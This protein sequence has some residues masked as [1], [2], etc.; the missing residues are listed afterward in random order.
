MPVRAMLVTLLVVLAACG[1][2]GRDLE[3]VQP[4]D[5]GVPAS[6]TAVQG[7]YRTTYG[8]LMQLR[9]N[10]EFLMVVPDAESQSGF[11]TL[12]EGDFRVTTERCGSGVTGRYD[13]V[14]TGQPEPNK[15][16]LEFHTVSDPCE[17]RAFYLVS[18]PW[19]YA[20]S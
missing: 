5:L 10:G 11:F 14:V 12:A 8:G 13:V 6:G 15:A 19:V 18:G 17:D 4:P 1:D 16:V 20:V 3:N 2:R 9:G 7:I